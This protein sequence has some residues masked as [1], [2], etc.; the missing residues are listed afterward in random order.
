MT[1]SR[2]V[3]GRGFNVIATS[4][5]LV[6]LF[7]PAVAA[8]DPNG[9]A[10]NAGNVYRVDLSVVSAPEHWVAFYGLAHPPGRLHQSSLIYAPYDQNDPFAIAPRVHNV[11]ARYAPG[12]LTTADWLFISANETI[13]WGGWVPARLL[14]L[15]ALGKI[16]K[17]SVEDAGQFF[18]TNGTLS[19]AGA[20]YSNVTWMR[21]NPA[22]ASFEQYVFKDPSGRLVFAV[23]LFYPAVSG[24]N[25][26]SVNYQVFLPR[27]PTYTFFHDS[28]LCVPVPQFSGTRSS[29]NPFKEVQKTDAIRPA[30]PPKPSKPVEASEVA[31]S[32]ASQPSVQTVTVVQ[33]SQSAVSAEIS[34]T[35]TIISAVYSFEESG[36]HTL[37]V[38]FPFP[39]VFL[40]QGVAKVELTQVTD[41]GH[42]IET[43]ADSSSRLTF[44]SLPDYRFIEKT[45]HT[46]VVWVLNVNAGD[47][48]AAKAT[49]ERALPI[50]SAQLTQ[51][52]VGKGDLRAQLFP[53]PRPPSR[54]EV[55]VQP[56]V[57]FGLQVAALA[58]LIFLVLIAVLLWRRPWIWHY[59]AS[60]RREYLYHFFLSSR[61]RH[62]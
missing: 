16:P 50:E 36:T 52:Q 45:N 9:L 21:L 60:E 6:F 11:T 46:L 59:L 44:D 12:C 47:V 5:L 15:N 14:D 43:Q 24:F 3:Q 56:V 28:R 17:S 39:S 33:S 35:R 57:A 38:E 51:V 19:L 13:E 40:D 41:Q 23:P 58:I 30:L 27:G 53:T 48:Y 49:I 7:F 55:D 18:L 22:N 1:S 54:L 10:V 26:A 2:S 32:E 25:N 8:I 20:S 29:E 31:T 34:E 61:K 37:Q 42:R 4:F 62:P